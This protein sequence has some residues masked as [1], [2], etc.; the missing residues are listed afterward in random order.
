MKQVRAGDLCLVVRGESTGK[1]VTA[2]RPAPIDK[3]LNPCT[4]G[5]V[6]WRITADWLPPAPWGTGGLVASECR[7]MPIEPDGGTL[8]D[9]AWQIVKEMKV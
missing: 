1:T 5:A 9:V 4:C 6:E 2:V 8:A 3:V 7:L